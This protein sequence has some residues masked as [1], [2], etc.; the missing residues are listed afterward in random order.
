MTKNNRGLEKKGPVFVPALRNLKNN[1]EIL[2]LGGNLP[3]GLK[4][5][6]V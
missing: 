6:V 5:I 1:A 4:G 3:I 2:P